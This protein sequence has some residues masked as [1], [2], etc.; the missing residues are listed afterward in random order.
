VGRL[1]RERRLIRSPGAFTATSTVCGAAN[2]K[3]RVMT[4]LVVKVNAAAIAWAIAY[5]VVALLT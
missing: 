3:G 5:A 1:S 4:I 2:Q